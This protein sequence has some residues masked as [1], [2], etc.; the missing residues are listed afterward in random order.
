ML[1][2]KECNGHNAKRK[3]VMSEFAII[4]SLYALADRKPS[5]RHMREEASPTVREIISVYVSCVCDTLLL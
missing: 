3:Y 1:S 5:N 4:I 2:M